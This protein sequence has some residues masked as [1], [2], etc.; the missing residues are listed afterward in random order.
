VRAGARDFPG[1]PE[2]PPK[3]GELETPGPQGWVLASDG[4]G[5]QEAQ[6]EGDMAIRARRMHSRK[7][8][9][10]PADAQER[11]RAL[12]LML[13]ERRS[14]ARGA[15]MV[16]DMN[17]DP[18]DVASDLEEEQV[19]LTVLDQSREIQRQVE[20]AMRLLAEGRYGQ[21][22]DC[23]EPIP[24][25]RL[26]ALPFALRCLLCQQRHEAR[27]YP[28]HSQAPQCDRIHW[29]EELDDPDEP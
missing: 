20:E 28:M 21:C 2:A 9:Y 3:R 18:V 6:R 29:E 25:P 17:P 13:R 26:R 19:W 27:G 10:A 23:G 8:P 11:R 14:L 7:E 22:L 24:L 12:E 4:S 15:V 5:A 16:Q 1:R